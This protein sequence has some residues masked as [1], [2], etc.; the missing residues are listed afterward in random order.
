[1]GENLESLEPLQYKQPLIALLLSRSRQDAS[2]QSLLAE[3]Q[4]VEILP[5]L[6]QADALA[7]SPAAQHIAIELAFPAKLDRQQRN[8]I[9]QILRSLA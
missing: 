4:R 3:V 2:P 1:M 7:S 8:K 9:K 6:P 5:R